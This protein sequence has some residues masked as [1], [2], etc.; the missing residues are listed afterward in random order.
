[1]ILFNQN[2]NQKYIKQSKKAGF[3]K[4]GWCIFYMGKIKIQTGM[5]YYSFPL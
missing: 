3:L 1:M 2:K 4:I 5:G